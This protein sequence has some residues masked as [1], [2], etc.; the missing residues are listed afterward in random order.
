MRIRP[1]ILILGAFGAGLATGLLRFEVPVL[2]ISALAIVIFFQSRSNIS[3]AMSV[4]ALGV[5]SGVVARARATED[6]TARLPAG[7]LALDVRIDD[8]PTEDG[9]TIVTPQRAACHGGVPARWPVGGG[10]QASSGEVWKV[11][12]RWIPPVPGEPHQ[13]GVLLVAEGK[14]S[15]ITPSWVSRMRTGIVTTTAALYGDRAPLVDAL[16]LNRRGSLDP[17]LSDAYARSGLVHILSISGFHVGLIAAWLYLLARFLRFSRTSA[18]FLSSG[19]SVLY[20]AFLGW[21]APATRAA[22]LVLLLTI[23]RVRQRQVEADSMLGVTCLLVLLLDPGAIFEL[24]A[25]LSASALWGATRFSRW[26]DRA[27]G[28]ATHWRLL[29]SSLGATLST[30]PFTAAALGSVA[31]IGV[32]LNFIAI[33]LA[34]VAVPGVIASVGVHPFMPRLAMALASGSGAAL[35]LLDGVALLGARVPGG[36]VVQATGIMSALPWAVVLGLV[37]WSMGAANSAAVATYRLSA[38]LLAAVVISGVLVILPHGRDKN[39]VLTL[40]FLKVGQGDGAAIRTP[41][42]HW[43]LVDAGPRFEGQDAGR[44]VVVPFL[45]RQGVTRL[46]AVIVSHVHADH[47]G[48]IPAV[49]ERFPADIVIEPGD[50]SD[51]SRYYDFLN[52]LEARHIPWHPGRPGDHFELDSVSFTLLHPDTTWAE[53]GADLNEDSVVLLVRY[54]GF[55]ALFTGDAGLEAEPLLARR[56]G[57]VDVLKV[58]H[59]GSRGASGDSFLDRLAPKAAV[60]SVG[61]NTYGHPAPETIGRLARHRIPT[62][63]TDQE[64]DVTVTTDGRTMSVCGHRGCTRESVDP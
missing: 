19:A 22:G 42:G 15:G 13:R 40:H 36:S 7:T 61:T 33:P 58:G 37:L 20:V 29:A 9:F 44:R 39:S 46:S 56:V 47:L 18:M 45:R 63:R 21:P 35:N 14:N 28:S 57:R 32:L 1:A 50:L 64:G 23:C 30:A 3:F 51:D 49:L 62:W 38:S 60:I 41:A 31:L 12:A 26:S 55:E 43:V 5:L 4:L 16:I 17:Q 27:L 2:A 48:G 34:A 8:P 54:R 10:L 6:C 11:E 53:W 24:G 59:H 52:L 25:W